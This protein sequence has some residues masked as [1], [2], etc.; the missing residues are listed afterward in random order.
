M[1]KIASFT[2]DHMRLV[3]GIYVSRVDN[4]NGTEVTTYDIRLKR[5]NFE[6]AMSPEVSHTIEHFGAIYL[7]NHPQHKDNIIGWFPMGCLT[8]FYLVY[9]GRLPKEAIAELILSMMKFI[10]DYKGNLPSMGFDPVSCGNYKLNDLFMAQTTAA[11]FL[12]LNDTFDTLKFEYPTAENSPEIMISSKINGEDEFK[13]ATREAQRVSRPIKANYE[14]VVSL[15]CGP[16]AVV[17]KTISHDVFEKRYKEE[18]SKLKDEDFVRKEP[19][20]TDQNHHEK[21]EVEDTGNCYSNTYSI[22]IRKSL[23]FSATYFFSLTSLMMISF[24]SGIQGLRT[25][26]GLT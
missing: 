3:P 22:L 9:K 7:R 8:G 17:N 24:G 16:T 26:F 14:E 12:V 10:V 21:E 11:N 23:N 4:I 15:K 5:P 2:V 20:E 19:K 1:E 6:D 25:S 18:L 13:R